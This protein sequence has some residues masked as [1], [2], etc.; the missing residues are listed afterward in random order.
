MLDKYEFIEEANMSMGDLAKGKIP[1]N[2]PKCGND[3]VLYE[4]LGNYSLYA[5][6]PSCTYDEE[7]ENVRLI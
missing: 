2:C 1:I 7:I 5:N 3:E 6:C 4:I